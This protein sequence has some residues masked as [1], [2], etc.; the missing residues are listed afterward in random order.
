MKSII[1]I[2]LKDLHTD[3]ALG[4]LTQVTGKTDLITV[5]ADLATVGAFATAV[6]AFDKAL[7]PDI[8]NSFT[9][10]RKRADER[11][12]ELWSGLKGYVDAMKHHPDSA[13]KESAK[14]IYSI[15]EKYGVH[16]RMGYKEEYPN[17]KGMLNDLHGLSK[18]DITLLDL[19]EWIEALQSAYDDFISITA[20]SV[21]EESLKQVGLVQQTRDEAHKAYSNLTARINAGAAYNGVEPYEAFIS[22]LNVIVGEYKAYVQGRNTRNANK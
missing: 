18:E 3:E 14:S 8:K 16:T 2:D 1:S 19:N 13:K 12:D 5:E 6:N 17:L 7:K 11:T 21:T 15:I 20:D 10:V 4:F 9:E 22:N